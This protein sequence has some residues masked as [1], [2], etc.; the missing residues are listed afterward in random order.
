MARLLAPQKPYV[1]L[2]EPDVR[3]RALADPKGLLAELPQ[4]AVLDAIQRCPDL[5]S[6]LQVIVDRERRPAGGSSPAR[7][8]SR[9][10]TPRRRPWPAGWGNSPCC[11]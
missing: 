10:S 5:L 1:S 4:G 11:R 2:E 7:T 6:Y 3:E 9:C 8:S